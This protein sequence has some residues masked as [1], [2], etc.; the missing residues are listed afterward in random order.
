MQE[1]LQLK[2]LDASLAFSQVLQLKRIVLAGDNISPLAIYSQML[3]F[4]PISMVNYS[5]SHYRNCHLPVVVA[6]GTDQTHLTS[7]I[8]LGRNLNGVNNY[9]KLIVELCKVV[10]DG[11]VGFFPSM[12]F[13][14]EI[15]GYWSKFGILQTILEHK[16]LF[17]EALDRERSSLIVDDYKHAIDNGYGAVLFAVADG[18]ITKA[19]QFPGAYGRACVLFGFP[20]PQN[21]D[22]SIKCRAEFLDQKFQIPKEEFHLFNSVRIAEHCASGIL[23]SKEDYAMILLADMRFNKEEARSVLPTWIANNITAKQLN[24]SVDDSIEQAKAFFLSMSQKKQ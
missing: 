4:E 17:V 21:I 13:L 12:P 7:T 18:E 9:G 22:L 6:R 5:I 11:I 8:T 2:C 24:F 10:P 15:I 19:T 14:Q 23:C 3:D 20:E 16:L 1:R